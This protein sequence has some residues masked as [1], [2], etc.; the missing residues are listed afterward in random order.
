MSE[1]PK[2]IKGALKLAAIMIIMALAYSCVQLIND[3]TEEV[4][5]EPAPAEQPIYKDDGGQQKK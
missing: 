3:V 1:E 5:E 4:I 2:T